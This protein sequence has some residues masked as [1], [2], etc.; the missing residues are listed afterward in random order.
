MKVTLILL[1]TVFFTLLII[2]PFV[3][4]LVGTINKYKFVMFLMDNPLIYF[5]LGMGWVIVILMSMQLY[6]LLNLCKLY[7]Q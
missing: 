7:K 4:F 6:H 5:T 1:E 2:L 3:Y